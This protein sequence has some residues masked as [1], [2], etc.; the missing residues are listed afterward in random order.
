MT[1]ARI[2]VVEDDRIVA[3]D[4]AQ[5][6]ARIGHSVVGMTAVGT[7]AIEIALDQRPDLVLMDV[8]LDGAL[9][10][11]EAALRIREQARIPVVYLTAYADDDTITR[12][13]MTEPFGY[14]L[15]PFDNS[16]L[17][18]V[19]EMA[20]YKHN[21]E[22][23]LHESERRYAATL[24]S[25]GDAVIA[26]DNES[27]VTFMNPVAEALTGWTLRD[28]ASRLVGEI[29]VTDD[30]RGGP[31][32]AHRNRHVSCADLVSG[33]EA[34]AWLVARSG[35]EIPVDARGAPI[36]GDHGDVVGSVLV[37]RDIS[38]RLRN[39]EA[40]RNAQSE[41]ARASRLTTM[42]E[43]A[44]S[45]AHEI[46]QPLGAV[47]VN[48]SA[49]LNF[50]NRDP[51]DIAE[52]RQV[53]HE[54]KA[55]ARRAADVIRSLQALARK[56][57]PEPTRFQL[58]ELVH[59]VLALSR[60]E[61]QKHRI[62]VR[63]RFDPASLPWFADRVQI[64]QLL[65]NLILNAIDAM[66]VIDDRARTLNIVSEATEDQRVAVIVEDSGMG[67]AAQTQEKLFD[68]FFTTKAEG[69]GMGLAICRSIVDAHGG[70]LS[71]SAAL[72][73]GAVFRVELPGAGELA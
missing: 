32:D 20:L 71:V 39:Q 61:L 51:P 37:F 67:I 55:D 11:V 8:R 7:E 73:H 25:I 64:Q 59:E 10:G 68:A 48:A 19:I 60:G 58:D 53:L 42:G 62:Q 41:L 6:L 56:A 27:R 18:T 3:R 13:S 24:S 45:I 70:R 40:L 22:R 47:A 14:L 36:I 15:K 4:I 34:Q 9:D 26:T 23:R 57:A 38:E 1:P 35:R 16:Q 28:A 21:A 46:N 33:Q 65:L 12:A 69:L 44:V 49:G 30:A 29:F 50:I 72:P 31:G 66:S 5:Q 17:R 43:L 54:V 2:L 63:T 52:V